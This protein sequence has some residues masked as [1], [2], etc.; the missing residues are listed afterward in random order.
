MAIGTAGYTAMLCVMA[1]EHEGLTPDRGDV[2]VTGAAGGVGSVA[3][4]LLAKLG[5]RVLA[6]TGRAET[7]GD[8]LRRASG[9]RRH[10]RPQRTL[11]APAARW[12]RNAGPAAS[13]AVGSHTLANA[14]SMT[15]YG[16][17]VAAARPSPGPRPAGQRGAVHPAGGDPGGCR[18]A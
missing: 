2:I 9:R 8:Y 17:V 4:A 15:K 16:G 3:I 18:L 11:R 14:L 13:T 6:S 7:E 12:A 5:Y 1:L 10:H